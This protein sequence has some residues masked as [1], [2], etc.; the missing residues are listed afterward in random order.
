MPFGAWAAAD[1][2]AAWKLQETG[3][4]SALWNAKG[5]ELGPAYVI[6][7]Y[8]AN[9]P[10]GATTFSP[11][12]VRA[13]GLVRSNLRGKRHGMIRETTVGTDLRSRCGMP[14][15]APSIPPVSD[16][17]R[18]DGFVAQWLCRNRVSRRERWL[19]K[20]ATAAQTASLSCRPARAWP[21][22]E[23]HGPP[24][25]FPLCLRKPGRKLKE[26]GQLWLDL[27]CGMRSVSST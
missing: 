12:S 2:F 14:T 22:A 21:H 16:A 23:C 4:S 11:D 7:H 15:A 25:T 27:S 17:K 26:R 9:A 24:R 18:L 19:R 5:K 8:G 6:L 20:R 3:A 13:D 10:V 1:S